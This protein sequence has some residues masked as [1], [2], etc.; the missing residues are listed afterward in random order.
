MLRRIIRL[1]SSLVAL[2]VTLPLPAVGCTL[3]AA[4]GL[5]KPP[6]VIESTHSGLELDIFTA[7]AQAVGC[8]VSFVHVPPTRGL[9]MIRNG[10]IDTTMTVRADSGS[11]G[12]YSE[13]Y[14]SYRNVALTLERRN[15]ALES[16]ADLRQYRVMAFQNAKLALG[17]AFRQAVDRNP[18]YRELAS[19]QT[20]VNMFHLGRVDVIVGDIRILHRLRA[21]LPPGIDRQQAVKVHDLFTPTDYRALFKDPDLRDRFNEGL[22]LIRANHTL[23]R[24]TDRYAHTDPQNMP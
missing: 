7:A 22:R 23:Q 15:I 21:S 17:P 10:D 13:P 6:Y 4:V 18:D 1:Y 3:R 9:Q 12:Y 11:E 5:D 20:Q 8:E 2:A 19:Q 14:I 16:V 24:I